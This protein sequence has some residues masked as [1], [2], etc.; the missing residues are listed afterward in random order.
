[1]PESSTELTVLDRVT[2]ELVDVRGETMERLA[3]YITDLFELRSQLSEQEEVVQRE[4]LNRLDKGASWTVRVGDFELKAA[5]PTAATEAYDPMGLD[6][7]LDHLVLS[8]E[9]SEAAA[10]GA[11]MR[12]VV[13]E[14]VVPRS[15][16]PEE[17]VDKLSNATS[18]EIADVPVRVLRCAPV[19]KPSVAGINRLRKLLGV[20][21]ALDYAKVRHEPPHRR[22]KVSYVGARP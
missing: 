19:R 10:D 21:E 6:A 11:L 8:D 14:V 2:G 16:S 1:M 7:A 9:I 22:V 4:L 15:A 20:G 12:G 3:R 18:I 13:I 5:S 17:I